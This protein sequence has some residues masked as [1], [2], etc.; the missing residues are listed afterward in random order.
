MSGHG[1]SR[2]PGDAAGVD[3]VS[4]SAVP[5][6]VPLPMAVAVLLDEGAARP[7]DNKGIMVAGNRAL[8]PLGRIPASGTFGREAIPVPV[9]IAAAIAAG[10]AVAS[11]PLCI[12]GG[13]GGC[14]CR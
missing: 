10:A 1:N 11:W 4:D 9:C 5:V 14:D 13:T 2:R 12:A 3:T 8:V 6:P 7:C